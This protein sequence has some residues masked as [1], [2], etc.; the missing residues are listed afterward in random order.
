MRKAHAAPSL[1]ALD[2]LQL[3]ADN[4]VIAIIHQSEHEEYDKTVQMSFSFA[5][6]QVRFAIAAR[7]ALLRDRVGTDT[8]AAAG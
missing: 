3:D 1:E 8:K 6:D 4:L 5:L 7:R 2:Q